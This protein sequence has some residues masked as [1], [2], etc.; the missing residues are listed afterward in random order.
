M[1]FLNYSAGTI[2]TLSLEFGTSGVVTGPAAANTTN[3][4]GAEIAKTVCV[5]IYRKHTRPIYRVASKLQ[6]PKLGGEAI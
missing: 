5:S 1:I 2:I 4:L 6:C 3:I